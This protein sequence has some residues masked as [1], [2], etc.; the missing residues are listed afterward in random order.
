M[1][2]KVPGHL[3]KRRGFT[4]IELLIVVAILAVLAL[5]ATYNLRL[6]TD[7][8]L[9]A[10]GASSLRTV[11]TGL[12]AYLTDYGTLPPADREGGPF[13]SHTRDFV[14]PGN[15]PAA[16]GS[17]DGVPWL[18]VEHRYIQDWRTMFSPRYLRLYPGGETIRGGHPRF[19]NFR[20][21]YNSAALSSGGHL[22]GDGHIMTGTTWIVR[23]LF[24][25]PEFSF[26]AANYPRYP[27]DYTFPWGEGEYERKLEHVLFSDFAVRTVIGG[28]NRPPEN[29]R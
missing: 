12:Q 24:L 23:D 22:G 27:A 17:W 20:F 18:L 29:G 5:V 21:A 6:A 4:L 26:Y 9:K 28:T 11:G 1:T 25:P 13:P 8:A 19:H 15:G 3:Q 14:Q 10:S 7:R 16:G 2:A